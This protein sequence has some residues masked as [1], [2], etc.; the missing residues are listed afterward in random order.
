[1]PGLS[2]GPSVKQMLGMI[3]KDISSLTPAEKARLP[4]SQQREEAK[5]VVNLL[6]AC[7]IDF[8]KLIGEPV[9]DH[10]VDR[11]S[12]ADIYQELNLPVPEFH[13]SAQVS[14]GNAIMGQTQ[15]FVANA[16]SR[17]VDLSE[18][19][20][21]VKPPAQAP[22]T[23]PPKASA[24]TSQASVP[25]QTGPQ[26][27]AA[28]LARLRQAKL[29][30]GTKPPVSAVT[31]A[32]SATPPIQ[33][34]S[35]TQG[36]L[37]TDPM[38]AK[39]GVGLS[40]ENDVNVAASST[41]SQGKDSAN[42]TKVAHTSAVAAAAAV[43]ALSTQQ[44][45][46]SDAEEVARKQ[47]LNA[48]LQERLAKMKAKQATTEQRKSISP[49]NGSQQAS[50]T[51]LADVS[52]LVAPA[53]F[54]PQHGT[55]SSLAGIPG[56]FMGSVLTE[57]A[58]PSQA[59]VASLSASSTPAP[60][61]RTRKRPVASDFDA[62]DAT[63]SP[64]PFKR[65]SFGGRRSFDMYDPDE[66]MI[67]EVSDDESDDGG[68]DVDQAALDDLISSAAGLSESKALQE[69]TTNKPVLRNMGPLTDFASHLS[70][71]SS[72]L[73]TPADTPQR[74]MA[75]DAEMAQLKAKIRAKEA[76][77]R[78]RKDISRPHTPG[79]ASNTPAFG[80]PPAADVTATTIA[81]DTVSESTLAQ[82][83]VQD[84]DPS[85]L[86]ADTQQSVRM[87]RRDMLRQQMAAIEADE[88]AE[89]IELQK[90]LASAGIDSQSMDI[91]QMKTA[92][93]E[94]LDENKD[95]E[96][97]RSSAEE[98]QVMTDAGNIT[99]G[100]AIPT[101]QDQMLRESSANA[102]DIPETSSQQHQDLDMV[103]DADNGSPDEAMQVEN[104]A[105]NDVQALETQIAEEAGT[106]DH[107]ARMTFSDGEDDSEDL[108]SPAPVDQVQQS[109]LQ[110]PANTSAGDYNLSEDGSIYS[111][112]APGTPIAP[113]ELAGVV[114][115]TQAPVV[116]AAI[117]DLSIKISEQPESTPAAVGAGGV[118]VVASSGVPSDEDAPYASYDEGEV[119]EAD[120]EGEDDDEEEY[121]PEAPQVFESGATSSDN[122]HHSLDGSPAN[123]DVDDI[124]DG[125][126]NGRDSTE[127]GEVASS[128]PSTSHAIADDL[129]PELQAAPTS[130]SPLTPVASE[131]VFHAYESPL[132]MFKAYRYHP[133]YNEDVQ[134]GIKS[135]T[136]SHRIDPTK[137]ICS[138]EANGGV[139]NDKTCTNQHF[140]DMELT[141][142]FSGP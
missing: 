39:P 134:G 9:F 38:L 142:A 1:M 66:Q 5:K 33:P 18:D 34:A 113:P 93:D 108:Y 114:Q 128:T 78:L 111:P 96:E 73:N 138:F 72:A 91:E 15:S 8:Q 20:G 13:D 124:E 49:N 11:S 103:V 3:I 24:P 88:A 139:C 67:I 2:D 70:S 22:P 25:K 54:L 118:E 44:K 140:K 119:D 60:T 123:V 92:R 130:Q 52:G 16:S 71:G 89:R 74:V 87:S 109:Q 102:L 36:S 4:I 42:K 135:L 30:V 62:A 64:R 51:S 45:A 50:L 6:A 14:S 61:S 95:S 56:L 85:A 131:E 94:L 99:S 112:D 121:E 35:Q 55:A 107:S 97:E 120:D 69:H 17:A 115:T 90:Q 59:Q 79:K 37:K 10:K 40:G 31:P 116:D 141:G 77:Q 137:Q 27:R 7:D 29:K 126:N 41:I 104:N 117:S 136:Y 84:Q 63:T 106:R 23:V 53:A 127:D 75:L 46:V 82:A 32:L 100:N 68:V 83:L 98:R 21:T 110:V 125:A 65:P 86:F 19:T 132:R 58:T 133:T 48:L 12:L 80:L 101:Q 26:D 28:Y 43:A 122:A 76:M 105:T 47:K 129:A 57:A 81:S